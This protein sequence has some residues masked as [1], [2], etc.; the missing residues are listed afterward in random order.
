MQ[1]VGILESVPEERESRF[2]SK[3]SF[4]VENDRSFRWKTLKEYPSPL[5]LRIKGLSW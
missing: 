1:T 4:V 2:V 3:E 5:K